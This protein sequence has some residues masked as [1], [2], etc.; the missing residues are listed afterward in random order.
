VPSTA[1]ILSSKSDAAVQNFY[2]VTTYDKGYS[3]LNDKDTEVSF[4]DQ[5]SVHD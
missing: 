1:L 2:P 4:S 3:A 5:I